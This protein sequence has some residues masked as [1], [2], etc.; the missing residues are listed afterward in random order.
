MIAMSIHM[1]PHRQTVVVDL[2]GTRVIR[3]INLDTLPHLPHLDV[4]FKAGTEKTM[5]ALHL[6]HTASTLHTLNIQPS[7]RWESRTLVG[8]ENNHQAEEGPSDYVDLDHSICQIHQMITTCDPEV[9][10]SIGVLEAQT[11]IIEMTSCNHHVQQIFL[12]ALQLL[13]VGVRYWTVCP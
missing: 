11:K 8:T 2:A 3:A 9:S 12:S 13:E 10:V 4:K 6:S 7:L 1:C 5:S